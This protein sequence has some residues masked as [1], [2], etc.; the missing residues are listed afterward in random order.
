MTVSVSKSQIS[1]KHSI[2]PWTCMT[3]G[4]RLKSGDFDMLPSFKTRL[5]LSLF[6]AQ[7][8]YSSDFRALTLLA[9]TYSWCCCFIRQAPFLIAKALSATYEVNAMLQ[10]ASVTFIFTSLMLLYDKTLLTETALTLSCHL[11]AGVGKYFAWRPTL[12]TSTSPQ[13]RIGG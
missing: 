3:V 5:T 12:A 4:T 2:S 6:E 8:F 7:C 13:M 10:S 1:W 11:R 9:S